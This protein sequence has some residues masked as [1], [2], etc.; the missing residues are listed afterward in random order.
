MCEVCEVCGVCEVCEV[1]EVVCERVKC[2]SVGVGG[3]VCDKKRTAEAP[4]APYISQS[5]VDIE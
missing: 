2:V 5:I 4:T 3:C 1:C